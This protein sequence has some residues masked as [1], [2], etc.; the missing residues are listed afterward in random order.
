[1]YVVVKA[2]ANDFKDSYSISCE[3]QSLPGMWE[4]SV[5]SFHLLV[6]KCTPCFI[7]ILLFLSL[8]V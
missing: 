7:L 6:N 1:M 2:N 3:K 4:A 5:R 8:I